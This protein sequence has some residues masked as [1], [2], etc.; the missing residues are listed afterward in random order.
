[1]V[2]SGNVF[3]FLFLIVL[4]FLHTHTHTRKKMAE[5]TSFFSVAAVIE[6]AGNVAS[7]DVT[8]CHID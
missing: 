4:R 2:K 8:W 7:H 1:M 5:A 3:F 6:P